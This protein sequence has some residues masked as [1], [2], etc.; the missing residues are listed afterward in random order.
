LQLQVKK[1]GPVKQALFNAAM[2]YK[3]GWMRLGW[4]TKT[5]SPLANSVFFSSTQVGDC[6]EVVQHCVLAAVLSSWCRTKS[7]PACASVLKQP[8]T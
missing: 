3:L 2:A 4:N 7:C 8:L 6:A 5:A 1:S